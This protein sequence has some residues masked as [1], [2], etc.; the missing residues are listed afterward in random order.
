MEVGEEV[1]KKPGSMRI[2]TPEISKLVF[3]TSLH[4]FTIID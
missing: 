1:P 2:I 3:I 4:E